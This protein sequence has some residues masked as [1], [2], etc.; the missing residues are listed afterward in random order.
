MNANELLAQCPLVTPEEGCEFM[1]VNVST[2]RRRFDA[3]RQH[4]LATY[5]DVGRAGHL[6]QRWILTQ[7]GVEGH[8]RPGEPVPWWLTQTG[9][10]T[11]LRW[12]EHLRAFYRL[13]PTLFQGGSR[14][15]GRVWLGR[16]Q[17]E[18]APVPQLLDW[19]FL[20]NGNL[21]EAA[22]TYTGDIQLLFCW[23]GTEVREAD[24]ARKW[25][26][27]FADM[28]HDPLA[29]HHGEVR[30]SSYAFRGDPSEPAYVP[31][32]WPTCYVIVGADAGA[33]IMADRLVSRGRYLAPHGFLVVSAEDHFSPPPYGAVWPLPD[34]RYEETPQDSHF[35]LGR[36]EAIV[37]PGGNPHAEDFLGRV[38]PAKI[39]TLVEEWSGLTIRQIARLCRRTEDEVSGAVRPM[40]ESGWLQ[41]HGGML[42]LGK[43][44]SLYVSRRDRIHVDTIRPRVEDAILQDHKPV[45]AHLRHTHAVNRTMIALVEAGLRPYCGWRGV[46]DLP[47]ITQLKP[48]LIVSAKTS[49]GEGLYYIEVER[50]AIHPEQ[51]A[52]KVRPYERA[53]KELGKTFVIFIVENPK[54]EHLFQRLIGNLP[55]LTSTLRDV[56]QGP[57]TGDQ[58]VWR[59]KGNPVNLS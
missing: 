18:N 32:H 27:R 12:V 50:T 16:S 34:P 46:R 11:L 14:G 23:V 7:R 25:Q 36:P 53:N 47:G 9:L 49:L 42:Y 41:E 48:D 45:G 51:V 43:K 33:C 10:Q 5:H 19:R 59:H 56:R 13:A 37:N 31:P 39:L 57:V 8:Y 17:S 55:A 44:G 29:V 28:E 26:G 6:E 40:L 21:V 58:T 1:A 20:K 38:L 35:R 54:V 30:L 4:G 24:L 52:G 15:V 2:A 22:V 3:L